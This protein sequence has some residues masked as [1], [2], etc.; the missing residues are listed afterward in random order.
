MFWQVII[1]HGMGFLHDGVIIWKHFPRY[2]PFARGIHRSPVNSPH[3]GQWRRALRLSLICVWINGWVNN[4]ETGD[5]R[6]QCAHYDVIV[7]SKNGSLSSKS[8]DLN[9]TH[10]FNGDIIYYVLPQIISPN[11][12]ITSFLFQ[13]HHQSLLK[14]RDDLPICWEIFNRCCKNRFIFFSANDFTLTDMGKSLNHDVVMTWKRFLHYWP[15]VRGIHYLSIYSPH[16]GQWCG[17][18]VLY[19][20]LSRTNCGYGTN[21]RVA[22]GF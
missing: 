22:K 1:S 11:T 20:M 4:H 14:P 7:M 9:C 13:M 15:F 8:K 17:S 5:L 19:L 18:P 21:C 2:W 16:N 3:K 10:Q 12:E 6:C